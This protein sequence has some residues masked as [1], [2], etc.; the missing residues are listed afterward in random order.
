MKYYLTNDE[1]FANV[2]EAL[3]YMEHTVIQLKGFEQLVGGLT[4]VVVCRDEYYD[5]ILLAQCEALD[6]IG[7]I[8]LIMDTNYEDSE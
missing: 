6:A 4:N 7:F 2:K 1:D 5:P 8:Q 3:G